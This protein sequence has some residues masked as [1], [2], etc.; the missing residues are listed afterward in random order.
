MATKKIKITIGRLGDFFKNG[1]RLASDIDRGVKKMQVPEITF[2]DLDT[3]KKIL[4]VR[5]LELL[6][7]IYLKKPKNI[8]EAAALAERD[9]KN[10]YDD[11]K[12]LESVDLVKLKKTEHG[13]TPKTVYNKIDINIKIPL[14][15]ACN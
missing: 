10:V 8:S 4:T 12:I 6:R 13:L 15:A 1:E 9:F 2:E 5:R 14:E 3:Y 7:L 11:I